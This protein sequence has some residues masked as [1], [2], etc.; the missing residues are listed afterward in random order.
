MNID[1]YKSKYA[2]GE[3]TI[4]EWWEAAEKINNIKNAICVIKNWGE[5]TNNFTL[6]G[7]RFGHLSF[8]HH[9]DP[10][11]LSVDINEKF[12]VQGNKVFTWLECGEKLEITFNKVL[13]PL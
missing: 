7:I 6:C 4:G 5:N 12:K 9:L 3:L 2:L 11:G 13:V 1:Y 10:I 8:V